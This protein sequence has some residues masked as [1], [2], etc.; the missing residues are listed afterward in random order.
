MANIETDFYKYELTYTGKYINEFLGTNAIDTVD[1]YADLNDSSK[2]PDARITGYETEEKTSQKPILPEHSKIFYVIN[3][4]KIDETTS[5][6]VKSINYKHGFYQFTGYWKLTE[7]IQDSYKLQ[8]SWKYIED[9]SDHYKNLNV[10]VFQEKGWNSENFPTNATSDMKYH[11]NGDWASKISAKG[12]FL[13]KIEEI[14]K[15]GQ[16]FSDYKI[17]L[18]NKQQNSEIVYN[19]TIDTK[20]LVSIDNIKVNHILSVYTAQSYTNNC[21]VTSVNSDKS[22][23]VKIVNTD[24]NPFSLA[25]G[26]SP[27]FKG[28]VLITGEASNTTTAANYKG[29]LDTKNYNP[30]D[31]ITN[32]YISNGIVEVGYNNL[33]SGDSNTLAGFTGAALG[34]DH[35]IYDGYSMSFGRANTVFGYSSGAIGQSNKVFGEKS[36]AVGAVNQ[37][38]A[39]FSFA[40]GYNNKIFGYNRFVN[41]VGYAYSGITVGGSSNTIDLRNQS[42][43]LDYPANTVFGYNLLSYTPGQTV[44]GRYNENTNSAFVVG[45]G[46]SNTDRKNILEL[47]TKGDLSLIGDITNTNNNLTY[48]NQLTKGWYYAGVNKNSANSVVYTRF[49]ASSIQLTSAEIKIINDS[50]RPAILAK[51]NESNKRVI[52]DSNND[53]E[54]KLYYKLKQTPLNITMPRNGAFLYCE[55]TQKIYPFANRCNPDTKNLNNLDVSLFKY[56]TKDGNLYN[57]TKTEIVKNV[58]KLVANNIDIIYY[59][60]TTL[61]NPN[62]PKSTAN[63]YVWNSSADGIIVDLEGNECKFISGTDFE[64]SLNIGN[65]WVKYT[66]DFISNKGRNNTVPTTYYYLIPISEGET[67]E[68]YYKK[69]DDELAG[70]ETFKLYYGYVISPDKSYNNTIIDKFTDANDFD[71]SSYS[72][73]I[74]NVTCYTFTSEKGVIDPAETYTSAIITGIFNSWGYNNLVETPSNEFIKTTDQSTIKIGYDR[75]YKKYDS[76]KS[77]VKPHTA[78]QYAYRISSNIDEVVGEDGKKYYKVAVSNNALPVN[79]DSNGDPI[80]YE[81]PELAKITNFVVD[82]SVGDILTIKNDR[83][84]Q[85]CIKVEG[86]ENNI[87]TYSIITDANAFDY[88]GTNLENYVKSIKGNDTLNPANFNE[89]C[90]WCSKKPN[91][92]FVLVSENSITTGTA[93]TIHASN[94]V[95]TGRENIIYGD[96]SFV[97]GR[98]NTVGYSSIVAGTSSHSEGFEYTAALGGYIEIGNNYQVVVGKYNEQKSDVRFAVGNGE[99]A[100]ERNNAFEVTMSGLT[101]ANNGLMVSNG[102]LAISNGYLNLAVYKE[103]SDSTGWDLTDYYGEVKLVEIDGE[104]VLNITDIGKIN[105]STITVNNSIEMQIYDLDGKAT[106]NTASLQCVQLGDDAN[107]QYSLRIFR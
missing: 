50:I 19:G 11:N 95:A 24:T 53:A 7:N 96:Y 6:G 45:A 62:D 94:S 54:E 68:D 58:W 18:T 90:I 107:P 76:V 98:N 41:G 101:K 59:D 30:F 93:N 103:K 88:N 21:L 39:S 106:G 97:S 70:Y 92:G 80:L 81:T 87:I 13:G 25:F 99:S 65:T 61:I 1:Y 43:P 32:K 66:T 78:T 34:P 42:T 79:C 100:N 55:K 16:K 4:S 73:C 23:T 74:T 69:S 72:M 44:F 71:L 9:L 52:F 102:K 35:T 48:N 31:F 17:W 85:N 84:V 46:T 67:R 91:S 36:I 51:N 15:S 27:Y 20:L 28:V 77:E 2:V 56:K 105:L 12:W 83:L 64:I 3:D 89:L 33:S 57:I 49:G 26:Y 10:N 14:K 38:A 47:N 29:K 63:R 5:E 40:S 8:R 22:I 82:L 60:N 75:V 104:L 86:I 37:I